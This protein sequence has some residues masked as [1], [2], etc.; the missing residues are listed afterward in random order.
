MLSVRTLHRIWLDRFKDPVG[1]AGKQAQ[2]EAQGRHH[3][4]L[5]ALL[6]T[7]SAVLA[8]VGTPEATA[9]SNKLFAMLEE[10]VDISPKERETPAEPQVAEYES[11][12]AMMVLL[13]QSVRLRYQA[14][15]SGEM[16]SSSPLFPRHKQAALQLFGLCNQD[17]SG[18][19]PLLV[20]ALR[21][22]GEVLVASGCAAAR[23]PFLCC[24]KLTML[25]RRA[26]VRSAHLCLRCSG[27]SA[28]VK[29]P[30]TPA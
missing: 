24:G 11:P 18:R 20:I 4:L 17:K 13:A 5:V 28:E 7:R 3:L 8:S 16:L 21:I 2:A 25:A 14:S 22:L 26:S 30:W 12:S 29:K 19:K 15:S 1:D 9:L 23:P 27:T 10:M 6:S